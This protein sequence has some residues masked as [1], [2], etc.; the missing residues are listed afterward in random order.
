MAARQPLAIEPDS[1]LTARQ[2][3]DAFGTFATGVTVV[4][5]VRA[6][7]KPVGITAN[8]FAS[9]SLDPPM[10]LWC[11]DS[12]SASVSAFGPSARFA[13]HVL[14]EDQKETAMRFARRGPGKFTNDATGPG[15]AT[16]P[17][18]EDTLCRLECAVRGIYPG[19]DHWIIVGEV[20]ALQRRFGAPLAFHAGSFGRFAR[21]A[22][23]STVAAWNALHA[24][25]M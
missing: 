20:L 24:E 12:R 5:G 15:H 10:I 23:S 1:E 14:A 22:E 16:P 3:R 21:E 13:V 9:V 19:G 8:S 11:L 2:L 25:W 17:R 18:L 4:T 7:G 6:D